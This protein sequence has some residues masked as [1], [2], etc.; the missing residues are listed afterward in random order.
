MAVPVQ[1]HALIAACQT[2]EFAPLQPFA[3]VV[4]TYDEKGGFLLMR[5]LET[6]PFTDNHRTILPRLITELNADPNLA[7]SVTRKTA[8]HVAATYGNVFAVNTL[9]EHHAYV[10]ATADSQATP[11]INCASFPGNSEVIEHLILRGALIDATTRLGQTALHYAV[12]D[13]QFENAS[14][15]L[16]YGANMHIRDMNGELPLNQAKSEAMRS[17][18]EKTDRNR[19]FLTMVNSFKAAIKDENLAEA[20]ALISHPQ[21]TS[22][23]L[24]TCFISAF[25]DE[26]D[27]A[28]NFILILFAEKTTLIHLVENLLQEKKAQVNALQK[29]IDD[30]Y[31]TS[32]Q[33]SQQGRH[34]A[35]DFEVG[36]GDPADRAE[37]FMRHQ[38]S[39][40]NRDS[41]ESDRILRVQRNDDLLHSLESRRDRA[42]NQIVILHRLQRQY[43][44]AMDLG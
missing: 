11:L 44:D 38:E 20:K 28:R 34:T 1:S 12:R 15:L 33:L 30:A 35:E 32:A 14:V 5:F 8:L 16:A 3:N 29:E 42:S 41:R 31:K 36:R 17:L 6:E 39:L 26:F 25:S 27:I 37:A 18:F 7:H 40:E 19:T 4:N 10:N 24:E 21:F 43:N 13:N 2:G 22:N 23:Y 9:L